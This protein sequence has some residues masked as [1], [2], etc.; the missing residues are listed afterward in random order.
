VNLKEI[1]IRIAD[2]ME[3]AATI[4][5]LTLYGVPVDPWGG[6]P[7]V[8]VQDDGSMLLFIYAIPRI[9]HL[10]KQRNYEYDVIK[11][12]AS[13]RDPREFVSKTNRF[14]KELEALKRKKREH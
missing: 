14:K 2:R 3:L 8:E 12:F 9:E 4:N 7:R 5:L 11:D 13:E 1:A 6:D 10:L